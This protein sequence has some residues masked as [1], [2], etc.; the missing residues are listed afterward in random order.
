MF[1]LNFPTNERKVDRVLNRGGLTLGTFENI[2]CANIEVENKVLRLVSIE[3]FFAIIGI[4]SRSKDAVAAFCKLLSHPSIRNPRSEHI[5]KRLQEGYYV[6]EG[7]KQQLF[8]DCRVITDFCRLMLQ[9]RSIGK[10][11]GAYLQYAQSCERFMVG[12]ADTGLVALIDEATGYRKRRH[13]EYKQLFLQFIACF[14][15]SSFC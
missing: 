12:L 8:I 5:L 11:S 3:S 10:I 15:A 13:D 7:D 6:G 14:S 9:L 2:D 1:F 4:S